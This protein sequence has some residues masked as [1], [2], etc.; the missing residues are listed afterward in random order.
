LAISDGWTPTPAT[1]NQRREPLIDG[2]KST[3]TR[4]T[5]ERPSAVQITTGCFRVR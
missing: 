4:A 5:V 3:A 2:P 1:P